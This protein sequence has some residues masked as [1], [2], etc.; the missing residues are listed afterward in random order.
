VADYSSHSYI[1]DLAASDQEVVL[2]QLRSDMSEAF[3]D[4]RARL[5]YATRLWVARR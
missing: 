5:A 1:A 3:P 4:G 2:G